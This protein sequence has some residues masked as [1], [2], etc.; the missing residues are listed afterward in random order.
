MEHQC[1]RRRRKFS[2]LAVG[3][4]LFALL[5]TFSAKQNIVTV[6]ESWETSHQTD[7][8]TAEVVSS[9]TSNRTQ[10]DHETTEEVTAGRTES[11]TELAV[12]Q[13]V[14]NDTA[15]QSS[16]SQPPKLHFP[17]LVASLYK[18]GTTSIH[19]YFKCGDQRSVHWM[20][21]GGV[22]TGKCMWSNVNK[23]RDIFEGCGEYDIWADNNYLKGAICWDPSVFALES[24]Y[25]SYPNG[26]IV[27]STRHPDSWLHSVANYYN[28]LDGLKA[29]PNLWPDQPNMN[30]SLP[31]NDN[32]IR[33]F[34]LWQNQHVRD[35]A[36]AH[37]S[38]SYIEINLE[39]ENAGSILEKNFGIHAS[40][41][42][43][44]NMNDGTKFKKPKSKNQTSSN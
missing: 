21:T 18:S 17:I 31:L 22:R 37:P 9:Q 30:Q 39:D 26:T 15:L 25:N 32:D 34:Y 29:C 35:F 10:A 8:A 13:A 5:Q 16:A 43:N 41:W 24:F 23:K 33:H 2:I 36:A 3:C 40:C 14:I 12:T 28:L 38:L 27:L 19:E 7:E 42:G 20:G 4:F 11:Q 1:N 6:D 44:K